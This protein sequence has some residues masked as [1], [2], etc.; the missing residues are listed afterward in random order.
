[1]KDYILDLDRPRELRFG[2]KAMREI[3]LKFGDRTL[4]QLMEI[5]VDEMP[6]LAWAGLKWEDKQLTVEK[7]EDMLDEAIP[8]K[9]TILKVTEIVLEA[10]A[11]QMG[12]EPKKVKAGGTKK[13]EVV[14]AETKPE[15]KQP[16]PAIPSTKTRKK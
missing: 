2:F 7:V 12:V 13:T 10:L 1:M 3:R 16:T 14:K 5:K 6:V 11:T 4:D 15:K 9:Y 8:A